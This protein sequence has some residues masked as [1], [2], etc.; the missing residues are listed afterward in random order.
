MKEYPLLEKYFLWL[1]GSSPNEDQSCMP[2]RA[3]KQEKLSLLSDHFE[4][5][6]GG[7]TR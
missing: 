4:L 2:V 5:V 1:F 7:S 6:A 3:G